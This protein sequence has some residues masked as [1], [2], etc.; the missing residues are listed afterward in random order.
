MQGVS[1]CRGQMIVRRAVSV[2]LT[3]RSAQ[4]ISSIPEKLVARLVVPVGLPANDHV[5]QPPDVPRKSVTVRP[6]TRPA[7]SSKSWTATGHC[8]RHPQRAWRHSHTEI[9]QSLTGRSWPEIR[10]CLT[11]HLAAPA[12]AP[13][14]TVEHCLG[15]PSAPGCVAARTS[16]PPD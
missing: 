4:E 11:V 10:L 2:R 9:R 16:K 6:P 3:M 5:P 8:Q 14:A 15:G 13:I 1:K 7:R 12:A